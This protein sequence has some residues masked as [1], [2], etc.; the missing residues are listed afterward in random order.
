MAYVEVH[1]AGTVVRASALAVPMV[2]GRPRFELVGESS[3]DRTMFR[4]APVLRAVLGGT[5]I[6]FDV[7]ERLVVAADLLDVVEI[8]ERLLEHAP[9]PAESVRAHADDH[10]LVV[11]RLVA[12]GASFVVELPD[13]TPAD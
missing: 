6:G 11:I 3:D 13:A 8:V 2:T 7:P 10:G 1:T 12:G 9:G 4:L 5:V